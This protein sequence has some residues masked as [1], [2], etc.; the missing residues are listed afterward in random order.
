MVS[1]KNRV[2]LII[3]VLVVALSLIVHW[4]HRGLH[5]FSG[6]GH[7]ADG[8]LSWLQNSFLIIPAV[9]AAVAFALMRISSSHPSVPLLNTLSLT[10][11]SISMIAGGGGMVEYHFSIFM[12]LAIIVYYDKISLLL[13]STVL[14]AAQHLIGYLSFRELV[15]GTADYSF[16]MVII[17]ILF[18]VLFDA[19]VIYQILVRR[20]VS[21]SAEKSQNEKL[22]HTV[23]TIIQNISASSAEVTGNSKQLLETSTRLNQLSAEVL[24]IMKVLSDVSKQQDAGTRESSRAMGEL[25]AG[26]SMIAD[27]CGRVTEETVQSSLEVKKGSQ[28][29]QSAIAVMAEVSEVMQSA[30]EK[31]GILEQRSSEIE[32]ITAINNDI[33]A[34]TNLLALNASIEAAKAGEHGRGF[35]VVAQ[36]IRKL[37]D[38]SNR[39]TDQIA[40]VVGEI[41]LEIQV[42]KQSLE[43]V[44][45]EVEQGNRAVLSS[46]DAFQRIS[47]SILSVV[48]GMNTVASTSEQ[49]SSSTQEITATFE[50]ITQTSGNVADSVKNVSALS[51]EQIRWIQQCNELS[52]KMEQLSKQLNEVIVIT[53]QTFIK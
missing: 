27:T 2:M 47:Q 17:H 36:E 31:F 34:Q 37:A 25:A 40:Q 23:E 50:D 35:A 18:V 5:L 19:G 11:A 28:S 6:T 46:G 29:I 51:D 53:R 4:L 33:A 8:S 10:M 41:Q 12:V 43:K 52:S 15:Y 21:E 49:L 16:S 1:E 3:S 32:G 44:L 14:F 39:A 7:A 26:I 38:Q 24:G 48:D 9:T 45:A 30:T 20:K 42:A 13:V 22:R